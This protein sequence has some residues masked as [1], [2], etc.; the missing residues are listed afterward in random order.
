MNTLRN[1]AAL[2]NAVHFAISSAVESL[3]I[4]RKTSAKAAIKDRPQIRPALQALEGRVFFSAAPYIAG[5]EQVQQG[6]PYSLNLVAN[7]RAVDYWTINWGDA[8]GSGVDSQRFSGAQTTATHT[9]SQA[10]QNVITAT[11]YNKNGKAMAVSTL[12]VDPS[13]APSGVVKIGNSTLASLGDSLVAVEAVAVQ[14]NGQILVLTN[15]GLDRFNA[16]GSVD[17]TFGTNGSAALP[18]ISGSAANG[19]SFT[20]VAI[21]SDGQIVIAGMAK[22]EWVTAIYTTTGQLSSTQTAPTTGAHPAKVVD[23]QFQ[24]NSIVVLGSDKSG[25]NVLWIDNLSSGSG[26][27]LAAGQD[28]GWNYL[29][30]AINPNGG[31]FWIVGDKAS[32]IYISHYSATGVELSVAKLKSDYNGTGAALAVDSNDDAIVGGEYLS[33]YLSSGAIDSTFA[34]DGKAALAAGFAGSVS[35]IVP[36][37]DDQIL[38]A[39]AGD[40]EL[41]RLNSDGTLDSSFGVSGVLATGLNLSTTGV[42]VAISGVG[43]AVVG[44]DGSNVNNEWIYPT[45]NSVVVNP[46][47]AP[48]LTVSGNAIADAGTTY[49]LDLSAQYPSSDSTPGTISSWTI[50]WGDGSLASPD[51]QTVTG[52]PS[53]VTHVFTSVGTP[54]ITATAADQ[55]GSYSANAFSITVDTGGPAISSFQVNGGDPDRTNVTSLTLVFN[56]PVTLGSG[57]ITLVESDNVVGSPSPLSFDLASSNGGATYTLTFSAAADTDGSLPNGTY[58][59]TITAAAVTDS[60][61]LAMAANQIYSFYRYNSND[62]GNNQFAGIQNGIGVVPTAS[63]NPILSVASDTPL[64][65]TAVAAPFGNNG[66]TLS[67][68]W[69]LV[70][71]SGQAYALPNSGVTG[72]PSL[73]FTPQAVGT[74]TASLTVT[75]VNLALPTTVGPTPFKVVLAL[76]AYPYSFPASNPTLPGG[77]D[78]YT[79]TFNVQTPGA[80]TPIVAASDNDAQPGQ[81]LTLTGVDFTT[82]SGAGAFSDTQILSYGQTTSGNG[83]FTSATV[84]DAT[85]NGLIATISNSQVADSMYLLWPVNSAGAGAPI[86]V[87]APQVTWISN[88]TAAAGSTVSIYGQNLSN[89]A[90]TAASFV[91]LQPTSGG[92][93]QW[94]TVTAVNPYKVDFTVPSNLTGGSFQVWLNNG[95]GGKY[96]WSQCP[97]TLTVAAA[98]AWP[99]QVNILSYGAVANGATDDTN[100]VLQAVAAI[101]ANQFLN[102]GV[103]TTLYFPAGTYLISSAQIRLP[104]DIQILGAGSGQTTLLFTG[105][106]DTFY[107]QS[108]YGP[109]AIGAIDGDGNNIEFNSMSLVYSGPS[110]DGSLVRERFGNNLTFNNCRLIADNGNQ[111]IDW[112]GSGNLLLENSTLVGNA[113]SGILAHDMQINN[114]AFYMSNAAEDAITIWAGYDISITNCTA[115]DY[116][117]S[118]PTGWGDGRLLED[119]V[120]WGSIYN[121][122]IADNSTINLG[123]PTPGNMGEQINIEGGIDYVYGTPTSETSNTVTLPISDELRASLPAVGNNVM[124][125]AGDGVGEM[126]TVKS[127]AVSGNSMIIT[128]NGTWKVAPDSSS[129]IDVGTTAYNSVFYD[130]SLSDQTGPDGAANVQAATGFEVWSGGYN[131][132]FDSNTTYNLNSGVLLGSWSTSDL[133]PAFF[134]QISNN[135]FNNSLQYGMVLSPPPAPADPDFTGV[136]LRDDT[137][138]RVQQT[139]YGGDGISVARGNYMGPEGLII[140]EGNTVESTPTALALFTDPNTFVFDNTFIATSNADLNAVLF[141]SAADIGI[142]IGNV[143]QGF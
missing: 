45:S 16:D 41:A 6:V 27:T 20:N 17:A 9:F 129:H 25:H 62:S 97:Q 122:Y 49:S 93:G 114:T 121:E 124:V 76:P 90:L 30:A 74:W 134:I 140:I 100:A 34:T 23:V 53:S 77:I 116:N 94:A 108:D 1:T 120:Y 102:P 8:S 51:V 55:N 40:Q 64:T 10:A 88:Q 31:D 18:T 50:N 96:S 69:A 29:Q 21:Q 98:M 46:A 42:V 79:P 24:D 57:A 19:L 115:Q 13:L 2:W 141:S 72:T 81:S 135:L 132:V 5:L 60:A 32:K 52:N 104:S 75:D 138:N 71:P 39:G 11:A 47:P 136:L 89:L 7:G 33:R 131:L 112:E 12:G 3:T 61:G 66:D 14:S 125:T 54:S 111:P 15:K 142:L 73:T 137:V 28:A 67:Y 48:T 105:N 43:Y 22:K 92:T 36:L 103:A 133:D 126:L 118:S 106:L 110:S 63:I 101:S 70:N 123:S 91:Y 119:S 65:I 113:L 44:S 59:L 143:D 56:R 128:L 95:L 80:D 86:A 117:E 130:N 139:S 84:Q 37:S 68:Q 38:I 58:N 83:T 85:T 99:T 127:V 26:S 78:P 35:S 82:I 4:W 107:S 87:N 109:F